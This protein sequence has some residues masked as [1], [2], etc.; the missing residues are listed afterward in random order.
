MFTFMLIIYNTKLGIVNM[1]AGRRKAESEAARLAEAE[2]NYGASSLSLAMPA[3]ASV[4]S[5]S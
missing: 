1:P 3:S 5:S 2:D 4:L